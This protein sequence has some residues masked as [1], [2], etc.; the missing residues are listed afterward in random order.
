[1]ENQKTK[2]T[3]SV[4]AICFTA[5]MAALIF[6]FTFTF[7]IPLGTG[8]TH[9]GDSIIFLSIALLGAKK[10]SLA[11]GVGAALADLIGG[12]S[13]WIVPTFLIKFI[14]VLICGLF[15]EKLI[16]N[17]VVGYV[18]GAIVGGTFQIGGYTLAKLIIFDKAYALTTLPELIIQTIVGITVAVVFI[19]VFNKT[20]VTDKL[21]K[22]AE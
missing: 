2:N 6:V 17:K 16:K 9:I 3:F 20:K 22:M 7:K 14:M 13:E 11:A 18:V 5:I 15:A 8:Y 19:S 1:M 4:R 12:Y 10:S 21:R